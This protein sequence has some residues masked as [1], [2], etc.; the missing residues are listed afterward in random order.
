MTGWE[1]KK[2]GRPGNPH[3]DQSAKIYTKIITGR[4]GACYDRNSI[5]KPGT[6][7]TL[8]FALMQP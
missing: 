6:D 4:L 5:S 1:P 2:W 3:A 7:T 8:Y